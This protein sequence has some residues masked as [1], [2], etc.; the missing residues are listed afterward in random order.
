MRRFV[1]L[2]LSFCITII[3]SANDE[4]RTGIVNNK[5]VTDSV[6]YLFVDSIPDSPIERGNFYICKIRKHK[7][8]F[9]VYAKKEKRKYK[10]VGEPNSL[11]NKLEKHKYYELSI[12]SVFRGTPSH[13]LI[14]AIVLF[15][16]VYIRKEKGIF[17]IHYLVQIE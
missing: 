8:Y 3:C 10:I 14:G 15:D 11:I 7:K 17:D 4:N 16:D 1:L 12:R 13:C 5:L 9:A 6:I 2:L